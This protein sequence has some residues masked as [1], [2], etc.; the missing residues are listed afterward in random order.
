M[1]QVLWC[2]E[3]KHVDIDFSPSVPPDLFIHFLSC[4]PRNRAF[5]SSRQFLGCQDLKVQI[6]LF[7]IC[8]FGFVWLKL[9]MISLLSREIIKADIC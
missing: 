1:A 8:I 4:K 2:K 3:E 9:L 6:I 7:N 5:I